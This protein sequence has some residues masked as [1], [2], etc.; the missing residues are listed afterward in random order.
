MNAEKFYDEKYFLK[1]NSCGVIQGHLNA[2][3]FREFTK[4]S[5]VLLDFGCGSGALLRSISQDGQILIGIEVNPAAIEYAQASGLEVFTNLKNVVDEYVDTIISNHA[6]EHVENPL[7]TLREFLRI[8][9]PGGQLIVVVPCDKV[10][11]PYRSNDP[12]MHLFSWSAGNLGNIVDVAGFE[13]LEVGE[14]KHRWPPKWQLVYKTVGPRFFHL[15]C[16]ACARIAPSRSQVRILA[17]KRTI[18][19]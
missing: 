13:I 19:S 10:S 5:R 4:N 16:Q 15:I 17:R 2:F 12:D 6:L 8:L 9:I 11:V 3:K 1:Q 7:E 18:A 14:L